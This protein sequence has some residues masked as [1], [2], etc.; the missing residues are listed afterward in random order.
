MTVDV[1]V[2]FTGDDPH[3]LAALGWVTGRLSKLWPVIIGHGPD[4]W[5]KAAAVA[6]GLAQSTAEI[7][8]VHDADVWCDGL[9]DAIDAVTLGAPWSMPHRRVRRLTETA[10]AQWYADEPA[11]QYEERPYPGTFGGGIVVLPRAIYEKVPL[12]PRFVGWGQEDQAW[13]WAL[14]ILAGPCARFEHPLTHLWHPPQQRMERGKGS[15]QS[16]TLARRYSKAQRHRDR[17]AMQALID[18]AKE[19]TWTPP[20]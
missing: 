6:D 14:D 16:V 18:E 5:C 7:V 9:Q 1:I 10:T 4:P 8:A 15:T 11:T 2:P 3:R 17:D 12:D 20:R 19:A 13:G